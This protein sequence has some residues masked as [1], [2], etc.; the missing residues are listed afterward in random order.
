MTAL[1]YQPNDLLPGISFN[2][3][4]GKFKIYG[5]SCPSNAFEF[6]DPL[7]KWFD[8][9]QLNP[10]RNTVLDFNLEYFNTSTAKFLYIFMSKLEELS[11]SGHVVKI[12]WYYDV[13]DEDMKEEGEEFE[14]IVD[15]NFEL[16]P[17]ENETNDMKEDDDN[18]FFD[19]IL[20]ST[21]LN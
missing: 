6:Y 19:S 2:K 13:Y 11:D 14:N 4:S 3:E 18:E 9:Y 20:D 21:Y 5:I 7:F 10:L 12:R 17:I 1:C 16:I 15:L 8:E